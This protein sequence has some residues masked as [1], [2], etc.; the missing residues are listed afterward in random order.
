[1]VLNLLLLSK[2]LGPQD[3]GPYCRRL[4]LSP[5]SPNRF[6]V[7]PSQGSRHVLRGLQSCSCHGLGYHRIVTSGEPFL[8]LELTSAL[9]P[10]LPC[11]RIASTGA[12]ESCL[13]HSTWLLMM[14]AP[15]HVTPAHPGPGCWPYLAPWSGAF[16]KEQNPGL[17]MCLPNTNYGSY[18][19]P[20]S[21]NIIGSR[22][23]SLFI[24]QVTGI[25][26][27]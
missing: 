5:Q 15:C 14:A 17:T 21:Q 24:N 19:C 25:P 18:V 9:W 20:T 1:M 6:P 22:D 11:V 13:H 2:A 23:L 26:R 3:R 7:D 10:H 27:F 12:L 4:P 16:R 8:T